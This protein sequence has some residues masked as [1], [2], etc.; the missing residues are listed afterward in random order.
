MPITGGCQCGAVRYQAP[1]LGRATICHCRMCQKAM[2]GFFGPFVTGKG[3]TVTRGEPAWFQSSNRVRR[4]FCAAC[5]T[6]LFYDWG[7]D[8]ELAI[9]TLDR[10]EDAPPTLQV[11]P[12]DRL[13]YFEHLASLPIREDPPGS[14]AQAFL[15]SI[16]GNQHPDHD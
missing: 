9:G 15:A 14:A 7:G 2:G 10:P 6:P 1:A 4:G 16:V 11:N 3:A 8:L 13:S 12:A 5:G